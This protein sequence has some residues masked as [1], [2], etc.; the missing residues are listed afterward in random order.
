M[1]RSA[2]FVFGINQFRLLNKFKIKARN[3]SQSFPNV[4][5]EAMLKAMPKNYPASRGIR[6]L[7]AW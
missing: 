6:R 3:I 5:G 1:R 7:F 2:D 4:N